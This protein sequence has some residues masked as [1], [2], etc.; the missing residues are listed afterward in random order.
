M[1]RIFSYSRESKRM[2]TPGITELPR[3]IADRGRMIWVD[4]EHPTDEE[5]GVLGGIFGFHTLAVEDCIHGHHLPKADHYEGYT[6]LAVHAVDFARSEERFGALDVNI[7]IGDRFVV[8]YHKAQIK[9]I[10]D[11]RGHVAKNPGSLLRSPDWLMR[12]ILDAMVDNYAPAIQMLDRRLDGLE[13]GLL[14]APQNGHIQEIAALRR[15]AL[16]LR[17]TAG[18]QQELLRQMGCGEFPW[19]SRDNLVYFQD[20]HDHMTRIFQTAETCLA[21][22]AGAT[23]I[24]LAQVASRTNGAVRALTAKVCLSLPLL[25]IAGILGMNLKYMP[26]AGDERAYLAVLGVMAFL[27]AA[28]LALLRKGRWFLN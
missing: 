18:R 5:T 22:I 15:E 6:F 13:Q 7:F 26:G 25:L 24:Y 28:G 11:T 8:T 20:I 16:H 19:I 9:G 10:S 3:H 2:E 1:I 27:V 23:E 14:T 21:L 12:G 4:L 17:R